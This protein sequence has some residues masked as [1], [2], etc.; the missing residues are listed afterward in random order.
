MD[1]IDIFEVN[2]AFA[3]Q[4]SFPALIL[5][6]LICNWSLA[7][8]PIQIIMDSRH[9]EATYIEVLNGAPRRH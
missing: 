7:L 4:V 9:E 3:S 8:T 5:L 1:D 2:E 6:L